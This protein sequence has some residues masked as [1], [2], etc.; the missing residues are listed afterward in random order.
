MPIASK[1]PTSSETAPSSPGDVTRIGGDRIPYFR[2]F[3]GTITFAL[4]ATEL[5]VTVLSQFFLGRI[6]PDYLITGAITSLLVSSGVAILLLPVVAVLAAIAANYAH[7]IAYMVNALTVML[8]AA[9]TFIV[10]LRGTGNAQPALD[11]H[12]ETE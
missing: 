1:P 2:L 5:V 6:A 8:A 12:P 10:V 4:V 3:L 9:I 7:D 11:P